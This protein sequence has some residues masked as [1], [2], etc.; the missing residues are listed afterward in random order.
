MG[1]WLIR[2]ESVRM[3]SK[4]FPIIGASNKFPQDDPEYT[5]N[6]YPEKIAD[7]VLTLKPTPGTVVDTQMGWNGGGRN[8]VVVNGS[9][10]GVRGN[11]FQE[12]VDGEWV[13]RGTLRSSNGKVGM[14][15]CSPPDTSGFDPQIIIVDEDTAYHYNITEEEFTELNSDD[16][17]F[18]GG[19]SQVAFCAGR[20]VAFK[21]GTNQY[22]CSNFYNFKV[23]SG[24]AYATDDSM[25]SPIIAL[26]SNGDLLYLFSNKTFSVWQDDGQPP[27]PFTRILSGDQIGCLSPNSVLVVERSVYWLGGNLQG[28]GV[29]YRHS[30]GGR[31]ERVSDHSTER[32][33]AQLPEQAKA[34]ASYYMA[35]G[36]VFYILTFQAGNRTFAYDQTTGLWADRAQRDANTGKDLA[37][38]FIATVVF[39]SKLYGL[40][41]RDGTIDLIDEEA[42]TDRDNP[43]VRKRVT[44][45]FPPESDVL[46][47][48][49]SATLFGEKGNTPV[50]EP[51]H[52][53][54]MQYSIDRGKSWSF[55]DWVTTDGNSTYEGM[56]RWVGLCSAYGLSLSFTT[57]SRNY[58]SWR[59]VR[60]SMG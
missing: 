21:P 16:D 45:V 6:M 44:S 60:L 35:F 18:V 2:G 55:E 56:A 12:E 49:G 31:P 28:R 54:M 38:P 41:Y 33:I 27:I 10:F 13:L 17:G 11:F 19:G 36:H 7:D 23:W 52:S 58:I 39:D 29:I 32:N 9:R 48:F 47:Y 3:V 24:D 34:I 25:D 59:G 57:V 26:C 22:Q 5:L 51:V 1:D 8:F 40:D 46:Y 14:A 53:I 42:F 20:A 37:L 43:I 4:D 15:Y 50:N 30:S